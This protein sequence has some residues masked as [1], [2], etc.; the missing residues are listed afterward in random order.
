MRRRH[1]TLAASICAAAALFP[2][3]PANV[4]PPPIGTSPSAVKASSA[5][6]DDLPHRAANSVAAVEKQVNI[7]A[8]TAKK[9][10]PDSRLKGPPVKPAAQKSTDGV[11]TSV[12]ETAQSMASGPKRVRFVDKTRTEVNDVA[13]KRQ[14]NGNLAVAA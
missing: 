11:A 9:G 8:F 10:K 6:M 1:L 5:N 4:G 13:I 14:S 12:R 7:G 3:S 2:G